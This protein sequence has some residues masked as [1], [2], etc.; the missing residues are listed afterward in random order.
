MTYVKYYDMAQEKEH[1]KIAFL[2]S[3]VLIALFFTATAFFEEGIAFFDPIYTSQMTNVEFFLSFAIVLILA[4]SLIFVAFRYYR[5]KP[6]RIFLAFVVFA[7]LVDILATASF[8]ETTVISESVV[9]VLTPM[10]RFRYVLSFGAAC[11]AIYILLDICPKIVR[12]KSSWNIYFYGVVVVALIAVIWSYIVEKDIYANLLNPAIPPSLWP[13]PQSFTN[14]R[15]TYATIL[16]LGIAASSYLQCRNH[17]WWNI[18]I[19]L[20]FY[21]NEFFVM[22]KTA[23]LISTVVILAFLA[24]RYIITLKAH[25]VK[26]NC[27]LALFASVVGII[28]MLKTTGW[29]LYFPSLSKLSDEIEINLATASFDSLDG[30]LSIWTVILAN[31]L[32]NPLAFIVGTGQGNFTWYLGALIHDQSYVQGYAHSGFFDVLGSSGIIGLIIYGCFLFYL[33]VLIVGAFRRDRKTAFASLLI[34]V[35]LILHGLVESTD[36]Y[37]ANSKSLILLI[38]L[39][40]PLLTDRYQ[41]QNEGNHESFYSEFSRP[42]QNVVPKNYRGLDFAKASLFV[43]FPVFAAIL[44]CIAARQL[45]GQADFDS[46]ACLFLSVLSVFLLSPAIIGAV[47][48]IYLSD[49]KL[50]AIIAFSGFC[51]WFALSLIFSFVFANIVVCVLAILS[52]TVITLL[53]IPKA[54]FASVWQVAKVYFPYL[55]YG[56]VIVAVDAI[57][58]NCFGSLSTYGLLCMIVINLASYL[59]MLASPLSAFFSSPFADWWQVAENISLAWGVRQEVS[60]S[61]R[62][63]RYFTVH[64]PKART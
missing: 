59:L 50:T 56:I 64:K 40:L 13:A 60:L 11:L 1:H 8:A 16:M 4:L 48:E 7:F 22:S 39:A 24:W 53:V 18:V 21:L 32:K 14:N 49:Q 57:I 33:L 47:H 30:R 3:S 26:N 54:H 36:L 34:F 15:N 42:F 19:A 6:N 12:S 10:M 5:F 38:M 27:L 52:G 43:S 45:G 9:Y 25:P 44:G 20:F 28:I 31:L 41:E 55:I 23:L 61:L 37:G 17:R 58:A 46:G 63:H 29:I 2:F 35:M 51:L 62:N